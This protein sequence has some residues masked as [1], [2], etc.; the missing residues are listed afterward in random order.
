MFIIKWLI[1]VVL[2]AVV[3]LPFLLYRRPQ[4]AA[5]T[6]LKSPSYAFTKAE[7]LIDW[8]RRISGHPEELEHSIFDTMLEQI[9]AAETFLILD[10]FLWNPWRGAVC[11][12]QSLRPLAEELVAALLQK[13]KEHPQ[14]PILVLTDPI[15]K[16]YGRHR[17]LGFT[18]LEAAKIPVVYTDLSKLPDANRFYAP[19]ARFWGGLFS[20]WRLPIVPNPMD[21]QGEALTFAELGRL[22]YLKANHRKVLV[23][24][25]LE[26]THLLIGS[27]NPANGSAGHSN[28]ALL[29]DG[30][31]G[32]YAA[33]S[34]LEVA[35][36][37]ASTEQKSL[38][39][40]CVRTIRGLLPDSAPVV[41][42]GASVSWLSEGRIR[43]EL[44][45]ELEHAIT[46][47]QVDVALFY[48]SER[49]VI[50][51]LKQAARRGASLRLLLDPNKDAF[52]RVKN[53]IPNRPVAAEFAALSEDYR[54]EVRWAETRGEQ[55]HCKALRILGPGRDSLFLGSA[56]WTTRNIGNYNLEANVLLESA[57]P[58]GCQFDQFFETIWT[59]QDGIQASLPYAVWADESL[60]KRWF[61]RFQEWS[62]A[63]TF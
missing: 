31:V 6:N 52:G 60:W 59:N 51:A 21:L 1:V 58:V 53:G 16:I 61:Y 43:E 44:L 7:L 33:L 35:E 55:F 11:T 17:Q 32:R 36:W 39:S 40:N 9:E 2:I 34:E 63:S 8:T 20:S 56:N 22:L 47:V 15:N 41:A 25:L 10:F 30:A 54:V 57:G 62:G 3:L 23:S 29:I 12:E 42:A 38:V 46:G 14:M 26:D 18:R 50:E 28:L 4:P 27:M 13:R 37:S 49:R 19:L 45:R 24:G 5:G 48:L